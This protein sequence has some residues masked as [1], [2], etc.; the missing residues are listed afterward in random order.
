MSGDRPPRECLTSTTRLVDLAGHAWM[1]SAPPN[2]PRR[3]TLDGGEARPEFG[4][5]E[6]RSDVVPAR[7]IRNLAADSVRSAQQHD[8]A[9]RGSGGQRGQATIAEFHSAEVMHG[10]PAQAEGS[11]RPE[12]AMAMKMWNAIMSSA[13]PQSPDPHGRRG[14]RK[15]CSSFVRSPERSNISINVDSRELVFFG[16]AQPPGHKESPQDSVAAPSGLAPV[17]VVYIACDVNLKSSARRPT[18]R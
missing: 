16:Y 10:I 6:A 18:A 14:A 3:P 12:H 2:W 1:R 9:C 5:L 4:K 7:Q 17:A 15:S 11:S 8:H 13:R